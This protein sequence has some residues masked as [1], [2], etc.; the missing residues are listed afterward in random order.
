MRALVLGGS[1]A[2][3][4]VVVDDLARAGHT[5]TAAGRRSAAA[6]IDLSTPAGIGQ[7]TAHASTHDVVINASGV[8]NSA[9]AAA[10]FPAAFVDISATGRYLER[11]AAESAPGQSVL[12]GAGLAPGLSTLL[13]HALPKRV[14]DEIDLGIALG[15]G[16]AHGPAAVA[17]TAGLAGAPLHAPPE[18]R[19]ITNLRELRRLPSPT[20]PRSYLRADFP[21][22]ALLGAAQNVTVRSYLATGNRPT[23]AALGLVG[24]APRL[25]PLLA[26]VPHWGSAEWSLVAVNRRTGTLLSARGLGQSRATGVLTALGAV[27]LH[28]ASPGR[29]VNTAD[30][31]TLDEV[32]DLREEVS[33]PH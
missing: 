17:W 7:V 20:G 32:P 23:T 30:V 13:V 3:G 6:R 25:A 26:Q 4:R 31:L 18:R 8:E 11:L 29:A 12:L 14:S 24:R 28:A 10:S 16:E 27:A 19:A 22:H 5:A 9:L 1:G 15:T 33:E 21:D 2:V